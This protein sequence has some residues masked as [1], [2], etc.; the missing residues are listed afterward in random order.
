[1]YRRLTLSLLGGLLFLAGLLVPLL[2]RPSD[3][4]GA[5]RSDAA[6]LTL[7]LSGSLLGLLAVGGA[8]AVRGTVASDLLPAA[9]RRTTATTV[10]T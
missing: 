8:V 7:V 9:R 2:W 4:E 5:R 10:T 3:D 1:M 6:A